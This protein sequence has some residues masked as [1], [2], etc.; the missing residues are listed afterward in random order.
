MIVDGAVGLDAVL[1]LCCLTERLSSPWPWDNSFGEVLGWIVARRP[2][3]V[4][5]VTDLCFRGSHVILRSGTGMDDGTGIPVVML[6]N[7]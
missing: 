6:V 2:F 1:F 5:R 7:S 3:A 4:I